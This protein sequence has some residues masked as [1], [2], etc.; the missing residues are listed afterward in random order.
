MSNLPIKFSFWEKAFPLPNYLQFDPFA[1]DLSD[2]K[3]RVMKMEREGDFLV[4]M[5]FK[6]ISVDEKIDLTD[7]ANSEKLVNILKDIK[8]EF[9]MNHVLISI[10][11]IESYIFQTQLPT[12]VVSDIYSAIK[13]NLEENVPIPADEAVFDYC[14]LNKTTLEKD[15]ILKIVVTV[16]PK[17][18]ID[19]YSNAFREAGLSIVSIDSES[20]ATANSVIVDGDIEP[21]L[22]IRFLQNRVAVSIVERNIVQ[23]DSSIPVSILEILKNP[24]GE[25]ASELKSTLNKLLVFWFTNRDYNEEHKKIQTAILSGEH[26]TDPAVQE[27]LE[28]HLKINIQVANPWVN[29]IDLN[30]KIP[31]INKKDA[32]NYV[33]TIGLML[34]KFKH[35]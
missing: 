24:E 33:A 22:S 29:C 16:F 19:F 21:Y 34:N 14:I 26:A 12:E 31:V 4:P 20:I 1:I 6:E 25:N 18:A 27:F 8:K 23:Y 30:K 17:K 13:F 28:N 5:K 11:E 10:P 32:L 7:S 15:K 35:D 2:K 9:K 3:I